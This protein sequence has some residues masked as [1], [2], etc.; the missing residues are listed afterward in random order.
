MKSVESQSGTYEW[1]ESRGPSAALWVKGHPLTSVV[2]GRSVT[3]PHPI[4]QRV[5]CHRVSRSDQVTPGRNIVCLCFMM[6]KTHRSST[7]DQSRSAGP[8][9]N[10]SVFIAEQIS[11]IIL[12]IFEVLRLLLVSLVSIYITFLFLV[13]FLFSVKLART[14]SSSVCLFKRH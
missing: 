11:R 7:S 6:N 9:V 3:V 12:K 2:R 13:V 1:E 8:D 14:F 10:M 5:W 4:I